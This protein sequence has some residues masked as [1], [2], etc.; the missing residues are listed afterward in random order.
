MDISVHS[1]FV[2]V[3]VRKAMRR[4]IPGCKQHR[5]EE[6]RSADICDPE[7]GPTPTNRTHRTNFSYTGENCT[8]D[9][10]M[11]RVRV[12]MSHAIKTRVA[13]IYITDHGENKNKTKLESQ[14]STNR[15]LRV[16]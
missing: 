14:S 13:H 3:I 12:A 1:N 10:S 5:S 8:C 11:T 6:A 4:T 9:L 2:P 15:N 16:L 7:V